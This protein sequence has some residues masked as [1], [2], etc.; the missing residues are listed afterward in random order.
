MEENPWKYA[1]IWENDL[2]Q[3]IKIRGHAIDY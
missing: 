2:K 3:V 1:E